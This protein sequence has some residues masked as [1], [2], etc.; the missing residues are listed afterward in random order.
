VDS[1]AEI[2]SRLAND[3]DYFKTLAARVPQAARKFD[4]NLMAKAYEDVY[5]SLCDAAI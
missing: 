1:L 2:I 5:Y 4:A 3:H